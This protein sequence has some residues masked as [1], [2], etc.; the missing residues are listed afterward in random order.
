MSAVA[1]QKP[2]SGRGFVPTVTAISFILCVSGLLRPGWRPI[3]APASAD[4]PHWNAQDNLLEI[5]DIGCT[6]GGTTEEIRRSGPPMIR[7]RLLPWCSSPAFR[8]WRK[9]NLWGAIAYPP[10]FDTDASISYQT[11]NDVWDTPFYGNE[12]EVVF[13]N[14]TDRVKYV[15][16]WPTRGSL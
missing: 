9:R 12:S 1:H 7:F 14:Y 8:E 16:I 15:I 10:E 4:P 11:R 6:G 3:A 13:T 5:G 2:L